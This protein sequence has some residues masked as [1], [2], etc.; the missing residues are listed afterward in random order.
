MKTCCVVVSHGGRAAVRHAG[1]AGCTSAPSQYGQRWAD[2]ERAVGGILPWET[3]L[4]GQSS[5]EARIQTR[6]STGSMRSVL[7]TA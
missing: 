7:A 2:T 1:S 5:R 3:D 4:C 6:T